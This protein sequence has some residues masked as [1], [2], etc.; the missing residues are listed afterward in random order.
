MFNDSYMGDDSIMARQPKPKPGGTNMK[1][2]RN[3]AVKLTDEELKELKRMAIDTDSSS[4][5][6]ATRAIRE[7]LR[8]YHQ[9]RK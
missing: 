3:I 6:I 4:V 9:S 8:K 7:E 1:D 2:R 5:D